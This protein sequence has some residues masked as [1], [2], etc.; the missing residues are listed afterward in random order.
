MEKVG[1]ISKA[2]LLGTILVFLPPQIRAEDSLQSGPIRSR[3]YTVVVDRDVPTRMRDGTVL[4]SDIYRPVDQGKFP[5]LLKRTPYSKLDGDGVFTPEFA[6]KAAARG[7]VIIIQDCRGRFRSEGEWYP[8]KYEAQDGYDTVEWAAGLPYGDGRV[9]MFG[10]S[11]FAAT[12]TLAALAH[13]PHLAGVFVVFPAC[14]Y[15]DGFGYQGGAFLQQLMEGWTSGVALNTLERRVQKD[16]PM[17]RWEMELPLGE[18]PV[19]APQ[20]VS[21]PGL[22]PYFFDWISHPNYDDY[23]KQWLT[24]LHADAVNVPIYQVAGWYDLFLG[25][26]LRHYLA[27]KNRGG[28][29]TR[30]KQWLMIGPWNH[31]PLTGKPGDVDF[32]PSSR[33]N[34]EALTIR[35]FDYILKNIDNG[36]GGEKPV[37]VFVMGSNVWRDENAWPISGARVARFYLHSRGMANGLTGD[38]ALSTAPP[39]DELSDRYLYDPADPVPTKGSAL[40]ARDQRPVEARP[41]VMVYTT[42][43][44][45][46]ALQVTG[47]V[48]AEIYASSSCV[49]T[50]FTAKL[51][52][53]W[54]NGY[55][56]NLTDGIIRARY[57]DSFEKPEFMNPGEIYRFSIDLWATGNVFLP[58]HRLRL[59]ISSSNFPRFNR[60]LNTGEDLLRA[61]RMIKA[62]NV[63][64][65]NRDHAS[66][67]I[68]PVIAPGKDVAR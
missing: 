31:G 21:G 14:D 17:S 42:S 9:G 10:D 29:V 46:E 13:P 20:G 30:R 61:T 7:Y 8:L 27:F 59:E 56:Q 49:D 26:T 16:M 50:D 54:P 33:G 23:W 60:N 65:H 35:W 12:A 37:K 11:Y 32:G 51:V 64:Y 62:T 41:D 39:V 25:G 19:L 1:Y 24:D 43:P 28:A 22:A 66:A 63:I 67:L 68:L 4:R 40:G 34:M 47:P 3:E 57:R 48:S 38:G 53:V 52:D 44:F 6:W 58:G 18:Y 45:Q 2:F 55:A 15:N 36:M 5:V